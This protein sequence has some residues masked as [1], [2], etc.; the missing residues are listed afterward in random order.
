MASISYIIAA[1]PTVNVMNNTSEAL[2]V[3]CKY[4]VVLHG[5]LTSEVVDEIC[6]MHGGDSRR[7]SP[8]VYYKYEPTSAH[9][10]L[11]FYSSIGT[12]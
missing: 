4:N 5:G 8:T 6:A 1:A 7:L 3:I 10:M 2:S 9:C 12:R 11:L